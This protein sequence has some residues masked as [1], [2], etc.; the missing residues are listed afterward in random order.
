MKVFKEIIIL[1]LVVPLQISCLQQITPE[2]H[3]FAKKLTTN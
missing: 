1:I 2:L 3:V